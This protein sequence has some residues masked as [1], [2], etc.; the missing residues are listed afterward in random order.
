MGEHTSR[1]NYIAK[2]MKTIR[3]CADRLKQENVILNH[4]GDSNINVDGILSLTV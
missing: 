2:Q 4:R 3:V 1:G